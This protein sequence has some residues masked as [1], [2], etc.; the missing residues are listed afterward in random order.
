MKK[1]KKK[2]TNEWVRKKQNIVHVSCFTHVL[3]LTLQIYLNLIKNDKQLK[4]VYNIK[5]NKIFLKYF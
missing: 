3:Q 2:S 1:T 5:K 4:I